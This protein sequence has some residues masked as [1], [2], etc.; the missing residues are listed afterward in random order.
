ML[1]ESITPSLND[2]ITTTFSGAPVGEILHRLYLEADAAGVSPFFSWVISPM[3]GLNRLIAGKTPHYKGGNLYALSFSAG[4]GYAQIDFIEK[5]SSR[6]LFSFHGPAGTLGIK[7]VYGN[8]FEQQS[9]TPYEHFEL[10][11]SL[12]M[13]TGKYLDIRIISDG[14]L[15]SFSPLDTESRRLSTGLSLHFDFVSSGK[16][17]VYDSTMDMTGNA[18]DWTVKYQRLFQNGF[19]LQTKFHGGLIFFGVSNYFSPDTADQILKNYGGGTNTKFFLD[20]EKRE[21]GKLSLSVFQYFLKTYPGT[22]AVGS[23]NDFWLF[24]DTAYSKRIGK[25]FSFGVVVSSV[26]EYGCFTGFPDIWK[27]SNAAKSFIAWNL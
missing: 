17:D 7:T 6:N 25:H 11:A 21:L 26:A 4:A 12:G 19:I 27:W 24:I 23:G 10:D 16:I 15:F 1:C 3:D 2:M 13:D 22:S 14:Y 9:I 5:S 20:I 18:L 8:P